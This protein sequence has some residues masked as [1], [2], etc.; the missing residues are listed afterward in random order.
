MGQDFEVVGKL[1]GDKVPSFQAQEGCFGLI[2]FA[3]THVRTARINCITVAKSQTHVRTFH[4][5][6][7]PVK[8]ENKGKASPFSKT[9]GECKHHSHEFL[10]APTNFSIM[11]I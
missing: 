3:N 11:R 8:S 6:Y 5:K 7:H 9:R 1:G 10:L 2:V 4:I